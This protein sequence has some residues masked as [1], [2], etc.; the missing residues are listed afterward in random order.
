MVVLT[1][2]V[3]SPY[4]DSQFCLALN[5]TFQFLSIY[6]NTFILSNLRLRIL[7]PFY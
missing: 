4:C 5:L 2:G 3:V 6:S 1:T 7:G